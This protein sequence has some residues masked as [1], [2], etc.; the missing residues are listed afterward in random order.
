MNLKQIEA[1]VC[2]AELGSYSKAAKRMYLTQ[3][4]ISAHIFSL[5]KELNKR[6]FVRNT[7]EVYLT[8]DGRSLYK[9]AKEMVNLEQK[10][11]EQF[12]GAAEAA[13]KVITIAASTIPSEYLLP[14]IILEFRRRYANEQIKII[15]TDSAD[16]VAKIVD[17][18]VDVGFTGTVLE[19]KHCVYIPFYKDELAIITPNT[20]KYRQLQTG[21]ATDIGWL[22]QENIIL[23][24]EGSGTRQE[25]CKQL[26]RAGVKPG[27][28]RVVASIQN[29]ETIKKSVMQGLGVSILSRLATKEEEAA[30]KLLTF[31][32]PGAREGR[33]LCLVYNKNYPL[34][35]TVQRFI[36]IVENMR[37][38]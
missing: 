18:V 23:R 31:K 7:K 26:E 19:K 3:P 10:I 16:V 12:A 9:Y 15:E 21:E 8:E 34:T 1:F 14:E 32:I 24:E 17:H 28:L 38:L 27:S 25:A 4:T 5:E 35:R 11:L 30:G 37:R 6:L 2:V 13:D 20:E 36:K 29:Q 33:E 22:L